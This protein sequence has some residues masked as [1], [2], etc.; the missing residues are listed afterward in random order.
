MKNYL[1]VAS[2]LLFSG[3]SRDRN[4]VV[5]AEPQTSSATLSRSH[6]SPAATITETDEEKAVRLAEAFVE[7]NGYTAAPADREHLT[8]ESLELSSNV[9]EIL[10]DRKDTLEPKAYGITRGGRG[11][12]YGWTVVFRYRQV[13]ANGAP[14]EKTG[15]AV[16]MDEYFES[17]IMQ[18]VDFLLDKIQKKL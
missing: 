6:P 11:T 15:R 12:K 13:P 10:A 5:P 7:R 14:N 2:L 16:T 17:L 8:N 4:P 1:L 3:C 9:E 18:H